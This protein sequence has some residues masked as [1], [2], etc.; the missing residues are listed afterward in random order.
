MTAERPRIR[1]Q[2]A[3]VDLGL[4]GVD[5][6]IALRAAA[7]LRR[8]IPDREDRLEIARAL[9]LIADPLSKSARPRRTGPERGAHGRYQSDPPEAGP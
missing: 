6:K 2:V 3:H 7:R 4:S 8:L 9:G 5:P 1:D